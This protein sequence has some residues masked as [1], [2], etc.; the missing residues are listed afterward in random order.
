MTALAI[1]ILA[2]AQDGPRGTSRTE[3]TSDQ[4]AIRMRAAVAK[5]QTLV[6]C[7]RLPEE[8]IRSV[9]AAWE[10]SE[11]SIEH[12][13]GNLFVK[14]LAEKRGNVDVL[15]GSGRLYRLFVIPVTEGEYDETLTIRGPR[16]KEEKTKRERNCEALDL[17]LAMR[18]GERPEGARVARGPQEPVYTGPTLC[19]WFRIF[20]HAEEFTGVVARVRNVSH[21]R[22]ALDL[23]RFSHPGLVLLGAKKTAL[24]P[25]EETRVY[26]VIG[27]ER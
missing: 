1:A 3:R 14:L 9:T 25:G 22:A 7:V 23:S 8:T 5:D 17:I 19:V 24:E 11:I 13:G 27:E 21:R 2:A 10:E 12:N 16:E 26:L 18:R 20:Y 15:G 6:S 4:G